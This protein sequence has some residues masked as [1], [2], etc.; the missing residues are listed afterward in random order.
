MKRLSL[1]WRLTLMTAVLI[2][3]TCIFLNLALSRAGM[4]YMDKLGQAIF[5]QTPTADFMISI[6]GADVEQL[7]PDFEIQ[8]NDTKKI[9]TLSS[10]LITLFV[11]VV[12]ACITY[13]VSGY[14]LRPLKSFSDRIAQIQAENLTQYQAEEQ[15]I[16]EFQALSHSFEVMLRRLSAA[17]SSLQEFNGNAAHE[18]RTPLAMMQAQLDLYEETAHTETDSETRELLAMLKE[19]TERLSALVKTLLEMSEM[20]TIRRTDEIEL[21]SMAEEVLADLSPLAERRQ[22]TLS[23]EG[24]EPIW[25]QGSDILIYRLLFNLVE[26]AIRYNKEGGAVRVSAEEGAD[27]V[28]I[29]VQ[30]TGSGIPEADRETIFQPFFRVDKSRSRAYGGVGL[31]LTLVRKIVELHGGTIRIAKSDAQGTTFAVTL[32]VHAV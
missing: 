11:T 19:Q 13:F 20:N 16:P 3:A 24:T 14:A 29:L 32:P 7:P 9:F 10:W 31:G 26:N 12:S 2:A 17:F 28:E 25:M 4:F 21:S 15:Q 1:Q 6:P 27:T 23:Q 22:I 18:F 8:I 30:D 5:H